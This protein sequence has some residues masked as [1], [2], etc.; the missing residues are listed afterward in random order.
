MAVRAGGKKN[1]LP[2]CPALPSR[3]SGGEEGVIR[4]M[5][6]RYHATGDGETSRGRVLIIMDAC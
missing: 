2:V 4:Q 5:K 1:L 3:I 6:V